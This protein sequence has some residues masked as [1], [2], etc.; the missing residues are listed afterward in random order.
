MY[1]ALEKYNV[2]FVNSINFVNDAL[3]TFPETFGLKE[4][5]KGY[6]PHLF[7]TPENQAYV[8]PI[9]P[10]YYYD[11]DH[12]KPSKRDVFL[13]WHDERVAGN[14][15]FDFQKELEDYCRSDVDILRRGMITFRDGFLNIA[16]IDPLQY[17][18]IASVCMAVYRSKYMPEDTIGIIK[19]VP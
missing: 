10:K 14:Y 6:F 13:T 9:P 8:G 4:L 2:R 5:K 1:M 17:V 18:T 19:D 7:N 11:P 3:E 15:V 12:M 16:N